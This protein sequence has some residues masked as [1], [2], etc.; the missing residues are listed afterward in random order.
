MAQAIEHLGGGAIGQ[1]GIEFIDEILCLVEAPPMAVNQRLAQQS[2]GQ[3]GLA[4]T[5]GSDENNILSPADEVQAGK[6]F[7]LTGADRGLL[8]KGKG[9]DTPVPR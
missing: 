7:D 8:V 4:G 9:I 1:G 5:R 6:A 2:E 3:A